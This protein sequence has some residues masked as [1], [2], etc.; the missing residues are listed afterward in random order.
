VEVRVTT[1]RRG[2]AEGV[3]PAAGANEAL[4]AAFA[5]L[6]TAQIAD[7]CVRLGLAVGKEVRIAPAGVRPLLTPG[8]RVA[9]RAAPAR[10][11]G[12]V[13]VFLE[14]VERAGPGDVL[15]VDNGGRT[16]EGCVGDLVALAARQAGLAGMVVWGFHRDTEGIRALEFPVW[17][18]GTC[19]F[20]PRRLDPRPG[21][22]LEAARFGDARVTRET[23][24]FAD[25]DGVLFLELAHAAR[26]LR[27]GA[28]LGAREARQ[29]ELARGGRPLAGQLRLAEYLARRAAD[30]AYT[31]GRHLRDIDGAIG[32][33]L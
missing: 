9:G 23:A 10:H 24:V 2:P 13:D 7:A 28:E 16:D 30:P 22:A 21:D 26:V 6:A 12:S 17:S 27:V 15:V 18:Y 8:R 32:E 31:F 29:A 1:A 11:V 20:G 33:E 4:A 19:P 3:A 5:P 14:A 25:E